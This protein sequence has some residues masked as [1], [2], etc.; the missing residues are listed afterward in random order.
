[1]RS[2]DSGDSLQ[3]ARGMTRRDW[4]GDGGMLVM[5]LDLGADYI[6]VQFVKIHCV[7]FFI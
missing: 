4:K 1:M 5:C 6:S 2:Q 3:G 7:F